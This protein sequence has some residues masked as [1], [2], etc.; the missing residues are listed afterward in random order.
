MSTVFE[1]TEYQSDLLELPLEDIDVLRHEVSNRFSLSVPS[2][3][4][5]LS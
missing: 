1:L 4:P 3:A 2:Q 5:A